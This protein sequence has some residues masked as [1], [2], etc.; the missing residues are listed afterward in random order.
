MWELVCFCA[1]V[2]FSTFLDIP[3]GEVLFMYGSMVLLYTMIH[4]KDTLVDI[5]LWG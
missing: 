5:Y 2:G 3:V 4:F 1:L